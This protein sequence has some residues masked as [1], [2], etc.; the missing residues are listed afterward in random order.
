MKIEPVVA[1]GSID[2]RVSRAINDMNNRL[3]RLAGAITAVEDRA[4]AA[5]ALLVTHTA[6]IAKATRKIVGTVSYTNAGSPVTIGVIPAGATIV[7]S[8]SGAHVTTAFNSTGTDLL[9]IGIDS[10]DDLFA[11]DLDV[12]TVGFKP[13]DEDIA[14]YKLA[15]DTTITATY[16]QGVANSSAGTAVVFIVYIPG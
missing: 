8:A 7:K 12:S 6:D 10:N 2:L 3:M 1:D 5:E 16:A 14:G 13:L 11:T 9:D 4:T 15:V